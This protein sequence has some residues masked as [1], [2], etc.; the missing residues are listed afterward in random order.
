[1]GRSGYRLTPLAQA[2]LEDIWVYTFKKWSAAQADRYLRDLI[3]A[4]D[5]LATGRKVGRPAD[6]R[7]GYLKHGVGAHLIYFRSSSEGVEVVR[8]LHGRMDADRHL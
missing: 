1:M 8:V 3:A 2:D 4:F 6:I 5:D 7:A